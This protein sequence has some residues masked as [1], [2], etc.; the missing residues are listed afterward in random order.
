M[1]RALVL[2]LVLGLLV[3]GSARADELPLTTVERAMQQLEFGD[4]EGVVKLL[5]PLVDNG[6]TSLVLR[7]ERIEALRTYGIAC[8]MTRRR[9]SAE[10]AFA[11]LVKEQPTIR[12]DP[13]LV[14]PEAI[15]LLEMVR[16]RFVAVPG[17]GPRRL[18]RGTIAGT[19]LVAVGGAMTLTGLTLDAL[20][21]HDQLSSTS[22]PGSANLYSEYAGIV[23]TGTAVILTGVGLGL[24]LHAARRP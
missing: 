2:V 16:A 20:A 7:Q 13:S 10:G 6:A 21:L 24:L 18:S 8:A 3:A 14:R 11:L 23:L 4:Y 17:R 5:E 19:A 1:R 15:D 22:F 9:A 12:F